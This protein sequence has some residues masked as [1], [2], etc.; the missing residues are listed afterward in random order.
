ML[1]EGRCMCFQSCPTLWNLMDCAHQAHLFMGFSMQEYWSGLLFSSP[2]DLPDP[3]IKLGSPSTL[4]LAGGFFYHWTTW[5]VPQYPDQGSNSCLLN[6]ECRVFTI[7]APGKSHGCKEPL[8]PERKTCGR[9]LEY[10]QQNHL[11]QSKDLQS[12]KVNV[13]YYKILTFGRYSSHSIITVVID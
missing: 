2:G 1:H 11:N 7:G 3:G 10:L 8:M 9:N 12:R 4:Y 13:C 5:E 6:W